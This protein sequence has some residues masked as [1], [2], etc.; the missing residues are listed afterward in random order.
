MSDAILYDKSINRKHGDIPSQ[1][2][3]C[4]IETEYAGCR[5]R[6]RLEARWAVFF[7][8][9]GIKWQYEEQGYEFGGYRYLPDFY[10]PESNDFVEVKGDPK[11]IQKDFCRM[12]VILGASS[13]IPGFVEGKSS[14][15]LLGEVPFVSSGTAHHKCLR[16]INESLNNSWVTFLPLKHGGG[17]CPFIDHGWILNSLFRMYCDKGLHKN[18]DSEGWIVESKVIQSDVTFQKINQAYADAR[19]ARFEHGQCGGNH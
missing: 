15:I 8:A 14:L 18:A 11:G 4:A 13:P 3:N 19:K 9:I 10:L 2:P 6:S 7:D 12:S 5:F 17:I 1:A 16:F